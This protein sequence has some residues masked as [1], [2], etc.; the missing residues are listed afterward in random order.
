MPSSSAFAAWLKR[1]RKTLDLTQADLAQRV[2]C[3]LDTMYRIEAGTR[4]PSKQ[5]AFRLAAALEIA[6]ESQ[7]A[8]LRLA[9][10]RQSRNESDDAER[11]VQP[12]TTPASGSF[13][14]AITVQVHLPKPP[15]LLVGR[16]QEVKELR[17]QLQRPDVCLVTLIGPPGVGKTC[18]SLE[19]AAGLAPAFG[20]GVYF[21]RYCCNR[22]GSS[23]ITGLKSCERGWS[24]HAF[25]VRARGHGR[26]DRPGWAANVGGATTASAGSL[27][28]R[29]VPS[30]TT[31]SPTT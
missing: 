24:C 5:V 2:G 9:R 19:T 31:A 25:G 12:L 16:E 21:V 23:I 10:A 4:R 26:M 29:P 3:S 20:D 1:R 11:L 14:D 7:A 22:M 17:A 6:P 27:L 8:F 13:R 15:T 18:V 30:R 28:V